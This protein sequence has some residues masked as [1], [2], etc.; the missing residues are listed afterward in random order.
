MSQQTSDLVTAAEAARQLDVSERQIRRLAGRGV[1]V[2]AVHRGRDWL[3]PPSA[4][5]AYASNRPTVG[6]PPLQRE[7][8]PPPSVSDELRQKI[9]E[10]VEALQK[11][12]SNV[13]DDPDGRAYWRV[14]KLVRKE[15]SALAAALDEKLPVLRDSQLAA[16]QKRFVP[17]TDELDESPIEPTSKGITRNELGHIARQ[18]KKMGVDR[19]ELRRLR[20]EHDWIGRERVVWPAPVDPVM[21][22]QAIRRTSG[23]SPDL[24]DL[25]TLY[26]VVDPSC[27][28]AYRFIDGIG[29]TA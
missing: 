19:S 23:G 20:V 8:S 3:I 11:Q 15:A 6:R 5:S 10:E 22:S 29:L 7:P 2:G 1:L 27:D 18:Q 17:L 21:L 9:E 25:R 13:G 4:V 12:Y 14:D 26:A 16:E 28:D 24:S